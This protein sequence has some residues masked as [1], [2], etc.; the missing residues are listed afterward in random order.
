MGYRAKSKIEL[1]RLAL[2]L[3]DLW[4]TLGGCSQAYSIRIV[5]YEYFR[6]MPY[7][8]DLII[9]KS[10]LLA[11]HTAGASQPCLNVLRNEIQPV[12]FYC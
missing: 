3:F 6:L 1:A 5:T 8:P 4:P 9:G 7:K 11:K 2:V 10:Y 12:L